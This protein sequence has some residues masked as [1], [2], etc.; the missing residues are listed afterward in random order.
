MGSKLATII[1]LMMFFMS[2]LFAT[3]LIILNVQYSAIN[4][5]AS[6][7][8]I[9]FS[10]KGRQAMYDVTDYLE[11]MFDDQIRFNI[12]NDNNS[13]ESFIIFTLTTIYKPIFIQRDYIEI[14]VKRSAYIGN[15]IL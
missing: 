2:V 13:V 14:T 4:A 12:L 1:G 6:N 15:Y 7:V 8:A 10:R 3:D 11:S 5:A 9:L